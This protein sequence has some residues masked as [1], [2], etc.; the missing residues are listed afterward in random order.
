[1]LK[2]IINLIIF[3]VIQYF[4]VR[5]YYYYNVKHGKI[6]NDFVILIGLIFSMAK[7]IQLHYLTNIIITLISIILIF[8]ILLRIIIHL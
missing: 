1:M 8:F 3:W 2:P 5:Y 6:I 4:W 7:N